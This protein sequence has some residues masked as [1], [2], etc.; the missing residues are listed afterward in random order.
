[1]IAES[2]IIMFT[3]NAQGVMHHNY[4]YFISTYGKSRYLLGEFDDEYIKSLYV[5]LMGTYTSSLAREVNDYA[6]AFIPPSSEDLEMC[7]SHLISDSPK[8]VTDF[9]KERLTLD[10]IVDPDHLGSLLNSI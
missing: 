8:V 4:S 10:V 6:P 1:M 9:L 5:E 3:K 7:L 2:L